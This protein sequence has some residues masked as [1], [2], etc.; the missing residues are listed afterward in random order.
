[1]PVMRIRRVQ[2]ILSDFSPGFLPLSSLQSTGLSRSTSSMDSNA[3]ITEE[4]LLYIIHHIFLPP[5]L[6]QQDDT[7]LESLRILCDTVQSCIGLY[8]KALPPDERPRWRAMQKTMQQLAVLHQYDEFPQPQIMDAVR[9]MQ[10]GDV[11]AFL[12]RAQNAGLILRKHEDRLVFESFEVSPSNAEVL[13]AGGKL[14]CTYPGPAIAVPNETASRH[15]FRQEFVSFITQMDVDIFSDAAPTT[16]KAKTTVQEIRDTTHPRYITELLTGILRGLGRP[17]ETHRIQK[18]IADD[19]LYHEALLPWRRSPLWL[20]IRVALQTSLRDPSTGHIQYK[21]FMIFLMATI[22]RFTISREAS[23]PSDLISCMH[24]K[25][26]RRLYKLRSV[27]P[28]FVLDIVHESGEAAQELL[29]KRWS[30]VQ[31]KQESLAPWDPDGLGFLADTRLSLLNSRSYISQVLEGNTDDPTPFDFRPEPL[32]RIRD[33]GAA[34]NGPRVTFFQKNA[35]VA[36]ADLEYVVEVGIDDWTQRHLFSEEACTKIALCITDYYTTASR[37]YQSDPV[38]WS[39]ML[40]TL[41]ELWKALDQIAVAQCPLLQE[42]SP[43]ITEDLLEPLLLSKAEQMNRMQSLIQYIRRRRRRASPNKS[44]FVSSQRTVPFNVHYFGTSPRHQHLKRRIEEAAKE[45]REAKLR[46]LESLNDRHRSLTREAD[47]LDHTYGR[48]WY[49]LEVHDRYCRKCSLISQAS[50]LKI[51]V[52]EWPL[53]E[54]EQQAQSVVVELDC[55]VP[56]HIWRDMTH[57]ILYDVCLPPDNRPEGETKVEVILENYDSLRPFHSRYGTRR[58]MLASGTKSFTHSHYKDVS[59]PS[60]E[61]SV[62]TRHGLQWN[63]FDNQANN[64][65]IERSFVVYCSTRQRCTFQ[66]PSTSPYATLQYA[67]DWIQ[68]TSNEVLANQTSCHR[69]INLHE[70]IAFGGLRSGHRLQWLNLL[71]ELHAQS[72][73]FH[74][75]EVQMLVFQ[76]IWQIGPLSEDESGPLEWQW[77]EE[78]G[79]LDFTA[80]LLGQLERGLA[81]ISANW[82]EITS[83]RTMIAIATRIVVVS[84]TSSKVFDRARKVLLEARKISHSWT[85]KLRRALT[86][87]TDEDL[88]RFLEQRLCE[89]AC[90]CRSTYDVGRL[91]IR[92]LIQSDTDLSMLVECGIVIYD[93]LPTELGKMPSAFRNMLNHDA[94]LSLAIE[95]IFSEDIR[96]TSSGF[97]Q[98]VKAF[99]PVYAPGTQWKAFPDTDVSH[100]FTT[101]TAS[102]GSGQVSESVHLNVL[103]FQLLINGK[104]SS[105]LPREFM[106]HPTYRRIFGQKILDVVPSKVPGLEFMT[107]DEVSGYQVS[108]AL[109]RSDNILVVQ[110]SREEEDFQLIPHTRFE[111]DLPY[112]IV[113]DYAHW[114]SKRS[115][116]IELRPLETLWTSSATNWC[117]HLGAGGSGSPSMLRVQADRKVFLVDSRSPT[118]HRIASCLQPLEDS[119]YLTVTFTPAASKSMLQVD[120][121]RYR[122]G[123]ALNS[124]RELECQSFPGMVVDRNQSTGTMFGLVNQLVLHPARTTDESV[125]D[126]LARR[127]VLVPFGEV[128]HHVEGLRRVIRID[129]HSGRL[130]RYMKYEVDADLGRLV[131]NASLT[132][133]LYKVYLH[134]L[135]GD[136]LPDPLTGF[137]GTEEALYDLG[138]A[139]C[140]S[141]QGL[142]V[143]DIKL[144]DDIERLTPRRTYYPSHLKVMQTVVWSELPATAQHYAF[145]IYSRDI[146][147]YAE[148]LGIFGK[149]Q[150]PTDRAARDR[151]SMQDE[152]HLTER[153]AWHDKV[154]ASPYCDGHHLPRAKQFEDASYPSRHNVSD[155]EGEAQVQYVARLV[156]SWPQQLDVTVGLWSDFIEWGTVHKAR[157]IGKSLSYSREWMKTEL[158]KTW[159]TLYE[160]CRQDRDSKF[161]LAFTLPALVYGP[162]RHSAKDLVHVL[163]A[164]ATSGRFRDLSPPSSPPSEYYELA[165]GFEPKKDQ[166]TTLARSCTIQFES[167]P[168]SLLSANPGESHSDLEYRRRSR[169]DDLCQTESS[170]ASEAL[171]SQ[172]PCQQLSRPTQHFQVIDKQALVDRASPLFSSWHHNVALRDHIAKVQ[173]VLTNLETAA[174]GSSSVSSSYQVPPS[175]DLPGSS[176]DSS[177]ATFTY[178]FSQSPPSSYVGCTSPALPTEV[179]PP[180]DESS[181][182]KGLPR[183]ENIVRDLRARTEAIFWQKYANDLG[184]SMDVLLRQKPAMKKCLQT[185]NPALCA[186]DYLSACRLQVDHIFMRICRE[187]Q[188][189][190]GTTTAELIMLRAGL[191]P[192]VTRKICLR[193]LTQK[194]RDTVSDEWRAL[195][196][197]F[198]R[199]L[200]KYQWSQRLVRSI[201]LGQFEQ[202][203]A[204]LQNEEDGSQTRDLD[205]LLIQID[206]NFLARGVQVRVAQEM[207]RPS[208][209]SNAVSQLNMGEGKSSVIIPFAASTLADRTKLVR[210]FVLKSLSKQM[211]Q[212]LVERLT[213]LANRQIFYAPF[214]RS[215]TISATNVEQIQNLYQQCMKSGG[216][217]L[218]QPEHI[219]S[220]KLMS[221]ERSLS[222]AGQNEPGAGPRLLETQRWCEA[223]ARDILDESDEILQ[224]RYQLIYTMGQQEALEHAPERWTTIQQV[225]FLVREVALRLRNDPACGLEIGESCNGCFPTLRVVD[226]QAGTRLVGEV[227]RYVSQ[228]ALPD[229]PL[230]L[231]PDHLHGP[232]SCLIADK[233]ISVA[234]YERVRQ[235]WEGS[236]SWKTLLLLRGLFAHQILLYVLKERRW[237]VD[238]GLDLSRSLLAVPFKAKDVP[239]PRAEFGHP[240]VAILLT[241]LSYYYQGLSSE[242][243]EVCFE[244]L[245]K[246]DNPT[247]EYELWVREGGPA[248]PEELRKLSGINPSDMEQRARLVIPTF[249]QSHVVVDFY[250]SQVVFPK[251]A[252]G[253][254]HKLGTSGWDIARIRDPAHATT[255]FSGTNDNRYLLPA[256]IAQRDTAESLGT[257]AE[258]LCNLLRPENDVYLCPH[259]LDDQPLSAKGLIELVTHQKAEIRVVLDVGAQILE[260]AN[261][262]VV[263]HW[264]DLRTDVAAAVFFD[265]VDELQVMTQDG[266]QEPLISSPFRSR[267]EKCV[268]YLDDAHTRGT[269][270][271]L[272][273]GF[274]AAVT[275]GPKV[276]KDRL[277]QGCMRMRKLGRDGGHSVMFVAPREVDSKIRE[278]AKKDADERVSAAD[279]IRWAMIETCMNIQHHVPHWVQQGVDY[280]VREKAW[281]EYH[282]CQEPSSSVLADAWLQVEA[283]PLESMYGNVGG[284]GAGVSLMESGSA[285]PEIRERCEMLGA[286]SLDDPRVEEE[287][288]R[289]VS[290][291]MEREWQVERPAKAKPASHKLHPSVTHFIRTGE[292]V[293]PSVA[294]D[295]AFSRIKESAPSLSKHAGKLLATTDFHVTTTGDSVIQLSGDY[296]RPIH[297]VVSSSNPARVLVIMSPY[298]V[299]EL[300]PEIRKSKKVHLHIYAPRVTQ[301]MESRDDLC[302]YCIPPLSASWQSPEAIVIAQ[303]NL[304]GGQ[305][306]LNDYDTYQLLCAFLGLCTPEVRDQSGVTI[307]SDGFIRPE[308]RPG[309]FYSVSPFRESPLIYLKALISFRRKGMTWLPTH[310][311]KMFHGRFLTH[312]DFE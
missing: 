184:K 271:R 269:D 301:A 211:F 75:M 178:L 45:A 144:L 229:C 118:F 254:P 160:L 230:A 23:I 31:R 129:V 86:D 300:L 201:L 93:Y 109:H 262:Q 274:R 60:T 238:Y 257:N 206:C 151:N 25:V 305:L 249:R 289:E 19:V 83:V 67:I 119:Q 133:R 272:P 41:F 156:D 13:A 306:Y 6:P 224:V 65:W 309:N 275:L 130:V 114:L 199:D 259:T 143:E 136:C 205:W 139:S 127:C 310:M 164:I 149:E 266:V 43:E 145:G 89:V 175:T 312:E 182:R 33:I 113:H 107:R 126:V 278:A 181:Q 122:L 50:A 270:L 36:L 217:L 172:W 242:D 202:T 177:S 204:E 158:R 308:D 255:G 197:E 111:G 102:R 208:S 213:G 8:Q 44:V 244:L 293:S 296:L 2:R 26:A 225:L 247:L 146:K 256:T 155:R 77:H 22:L 189:D 307:Q 169:Y 282:S 131:S 191:W 135:T 233:D 95:T 11:L 263:R 88:I 281:Q 52:H 183:L 234:D 185:P 14:L 216:I 46:E 123:F 280:Y 179:V 152:R 4:N 82:T 5:E 99:W 212:L 61:T 253:F 85:R 168:A 115:K 153:S 87:A 64:V 200:L 62:C 241:C 34:L 221:V 1:M 196:T 132:S 147:Q 298:E 264:L 68:H 12:I 294:F 162:Q 39:V 101:D 226:M 239:S 246:L 227:M 209:G 29:Q 81:A 186:P 76:L 188:P 56:Y 28:R 240:D 108:F 190:A 236:N 235:Y 159:M 228:G 106:E 32:P 258:V 277:V 171:V 303:L 154:F 173:A 142:S 110:A 268:V 20:V 295:G 103:T 243:L 3:T 248:V 100:W 116:Q 80:A 74:K 124:N 157:Q 223:N 287:Q 250:L 128:T 141:F 134:A 49:G 237:R 38:L 137:T 290:H 267:L 17:E 84:A 283:Q 284:E 192:R 90:T 21:S 105:R 58:V 276:T 195:F 69:D 176:P 174:R 73:T 194:L 193:Y 53:P 260:L 279:V 292:V 112:F 18:R 311:G 215:M 30:V 148:S 161:Q 299:N 10:T 218:A 291:E 207:I 261:D 198:A 66:L 120:L 297:W 231:L 210:V 54:N 167:S 140:R 286:V 47:S 42:Y 302:F 27:C 104:P 138:S 48:T 15:D 94:R 214:S 180:E 222:V 166:I 203:L 96:Q 37:V 55:P 163:L 57:T 7:D 304:V 220:F 72:L 78:L 251:A 232:T 79:H 288:E 219:L 273:S 265:D 71:R 51:R 59:I 285:I 187:L 16:T 121:T 97:H 252:K 40:L 117:I 9:T 63:L 70:Y 150:R 24:K 170:R 125:A 245:S 98:A 91:N 165:A 35:I 92:E